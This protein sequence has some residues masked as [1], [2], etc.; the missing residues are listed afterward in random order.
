[1]SASHHSTQRKRDVLGRL[2]PGPSQPV[3]SRFW[4]K[5]QKTDTC[6]LWTG[7]QNPAGYGTFWLDGTVV[8]SHRVAY[9]LTQGPICEG[10][11]LDHL[12]NVKHCVN[13]DHL[14]AV[15]H[16]ENGLRSEA[17]NIQLHRAGTCKRG[18]PVNDTN[19]YFRKSGP[20]AGEV[21][22]CKICERENRNKRK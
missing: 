3:V 8:N 2:L 21:V 5:V 14:E 10:L 16:R 7:S 12:C 13:P 20:R 11:E 4:A 18:H 17:P 19:T 15:T 22:Y 9:E 6:W 1:M